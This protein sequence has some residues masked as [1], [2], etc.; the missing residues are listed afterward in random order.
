MSSPLGMFHITANDKSNRRRK[1]LIARSR[2]CYFFL[3]AIDWQESSHT[4]T[5]VEETSATVE[6]GRKAERGE[7]ANEIDLSLSV[8]CMLVVYASA[9]LSLSFVESEKNAK[10]KNI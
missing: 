5:H 10:E 3:L 7:K 4:H 9:L 8:I 2:C 6:R 1:D